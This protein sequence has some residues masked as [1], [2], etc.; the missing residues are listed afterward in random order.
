MERRKGQDE[1]GRDKAKARGPLAER[2][3]LRTGDTRPNLE[4]VREE[5]PPPLGLLLTPGT[6]SEGKSW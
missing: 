4:V 3:L 5:E 2:H 6:G 1:E